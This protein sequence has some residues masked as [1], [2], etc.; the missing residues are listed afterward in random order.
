MI[1]EFIGFRLDVE[2]IKQLDD[3][4]RTVNRTRSGLII[5]IIKKWLENQKAKED[6]E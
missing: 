1:K 3:L 6:W 2:T 4:A 5:H